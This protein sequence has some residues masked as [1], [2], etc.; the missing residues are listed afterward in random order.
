LQSGPSLVGGLRK[1]SNQ[2]GQA[3]TKK[4]NEKTVIR[5]KRKNNT[6]SKEKT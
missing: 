5:E 4:K 1:K 2:S 6:E 3:E